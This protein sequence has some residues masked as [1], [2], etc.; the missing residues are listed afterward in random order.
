MNKKKIHLENWDGGGE[1]GC[2]DE[3]DHLFCMTYSENA[4]TTTYK[5]YVTCKRCLKLI[6]KMDSQND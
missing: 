1:S 2:D 5:K 4:E 6:S 3:P